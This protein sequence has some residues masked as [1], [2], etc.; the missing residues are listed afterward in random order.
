MKKR[1]TWKAGALIVIELENGL[2]TVA[3]MIANTIMRFYDIKSHNDDWENI[4]W[5]EVK[6]LFLVFVGTVVQRDLGVRKIT[7]DSI[8]TLHENIKLYWIKPY[9]S[10]DISHYK[11][12]SGSFPFLGDYQ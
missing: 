4:N 6:P 8:A 11:G 5:P 12:T 9:A 1:I 7:I 10:M 2:F 3:Q